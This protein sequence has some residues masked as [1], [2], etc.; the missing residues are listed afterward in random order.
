MIARYLRYLRNRIMTEPKRNIISIV[1]TTGVGKS[2]FSIDLARA[3]NGEIINADSMQVY[4]K[5]DNITNKHPMEERYGVPHHVMNHVNWNEEYFIHRFSE[6]ANKA[7]EDIY[8][9]GKIPIIIGG[10]HY[11][12]SNLLFNNK[13][14]G[15]STEEIEQKQ[16]SEDQ[17]KLLDGPVENIFEELKNIDPIIVEKFHPQDKRKLRRAL[18]IFY[19]TGEKPSSIYHDQKL[20]ELENSSLKYNTLLFWV[21]SDPEVLKKR[22]DTRVDKMMESG[23]LE[24]IKELYDVYKSQ[25]P[26]PDCSSGI[27]QVIGFKEFIPW[28]DATNGEEIDNPLYKEGVERMQIRTRQYA[29]YQ[30]KWIKKLLSVELQKESRFGFKYGGK[31]YLLDA[32]D[33]NVW[34][35]NVSSRGVE[36]TKQFL[37]GGPKAI[38]LPQA[39]ENLKEMIPDDDFFSSYKSNKVIGSESNWKH[40]TCPI[41]K[42]KNGNALI[43]VGD[44]SWQIHVNSKRHKKQVSAGEKKRKH[45]ELLKQ[46]GDSTVTEKSRKS[47]KLDEQ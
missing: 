1:G 10:T 37:A 45:L 18:E 35:S 4:K 5:L 27:W 26:P 7:I 41:C 15:N 36:I 12:L 32:T 24:E 29:K 13:T 3:I 8:S 46:Y 2:Q 6:E 22:L 38:T 19:E 43:A 34:N 31:L 14:I 30:V 33:L 9:R 17:I 39:P 25:S 28:L 11:Y 16:L 44:E 23:A 40:Y 21:Y 47:L 20:E 42:D